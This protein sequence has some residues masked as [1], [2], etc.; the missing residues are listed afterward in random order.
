MHGQAAVSDDLKAGD[1][2]MRSLESRYADNEFA[3]YFLEHYWKERDYF[4]ARGGW[5]KNAK[6]LEAFIQSF[7]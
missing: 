7:L 2:L 3:L 6:G 1:E 4:A 5:T